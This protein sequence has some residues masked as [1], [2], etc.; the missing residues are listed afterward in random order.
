MAAEF[1]AYHKWL[2]IPPAEQPPNHYRLLALNVFEGDPDVIDSAANV[3]MIHLRSLQTGPQAELTQK[4]L[5]EIAAARLCLLKPEKKSSYDASLQAQLT[6]GVRAK[7]PPPPPLP[8]TASTPATP[9]VAAPAESAA[10]LLDFISASYEPPKTAVGAARA[11]KV[12]RF[13]FL[14][15]L[16]PLAGI[17]LVAAAIAFRNSRKP[18]EPTT[19]TNRSTTSTAATMPATP[20]GSN[21]TGS[22]DHRA[23]AAA[24]SSS[25]ERTIEN[26][27]IAKTDS[28]L[29]AAA[30]ASGNRGNTAASSDENKLAKHSSGST[31]ASGANSNVQAVLP[32]APAICGCNT[33]AWKPSR[34]R[35]R[36]A[37]TFESKTMAIARFPSRS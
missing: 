7:S 19:A 33:V 9:P 25:V 28:P 3:R 24:E 11:K 13:R 5:N 26:P 15:A 22:P 36:F 14:L 17:G 21:A 4:L 1:D 29:P 18:I 32:R 31:T 8:Q 12:A 23:H 2:A 20:T 37:A 30:V 6:R 16:A 34:R 27:R 35:I 10:T